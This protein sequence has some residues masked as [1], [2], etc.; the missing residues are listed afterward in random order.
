MM[1]IGKFVYRTLVGDGYNDDDRQ[2]YVQSFSG[3]E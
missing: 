1:M 2:V 3:R